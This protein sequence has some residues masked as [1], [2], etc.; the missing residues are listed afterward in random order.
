M[1]AAC[2][3]HPTNDEQ[4][5]LTMKGATVSSTPLLCQFVQLE[6]YS[7]LLLLDVM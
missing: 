4:S 2:G 3:V 7:L 1:S 5:V 6:E